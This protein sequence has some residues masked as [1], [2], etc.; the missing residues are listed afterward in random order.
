MAASQRQGVDSSDEYGADDI[1]R[2]RQRMAC[3]DRGH[4]LLVDHMPIQFTPTEY[5]IVRELVL[6]FTQPVAFRV[7]TRAA[8]DRQDT[9]DARRLLERHIDRIRLK[10][11]DD[12]IPVQLAVRYVNECG[13]VLL[14]RA[15]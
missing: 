6:R 14:P 9:L 11:R 8:F 2:W 10:L 3:H 13:Y 7:L 4:L 12:S 1:A 15:W 5:A